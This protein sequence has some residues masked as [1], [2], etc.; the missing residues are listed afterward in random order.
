MT[1]QIIDK[2]ILTYTSDMRSE[3]ISDISNVY[4][5]IGVSNVSKPARCVRDPGALSVWHL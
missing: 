1:R 2:L 3:N 4:I 5:R